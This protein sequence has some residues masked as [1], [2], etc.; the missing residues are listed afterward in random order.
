MCVHCTYDDA[1]A[2]NSN[3]DE[4]R[5]SRAF[6]RA[7]AHTQRQFTTETARKWSIIIVAAAVA[8]ASESA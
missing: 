3:D 7:R 6:E 5:W 1:R 8:T 2:R 4:I